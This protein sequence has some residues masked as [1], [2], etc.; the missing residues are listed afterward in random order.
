MSRTAIPVA[1]A[2]LNGSVVAS[3]AAIDIANGM[4]LSGFP[5]RTVVQI[6]NTAGSGHTVTVEAGDPVGGVSE[7]LAETFFVPAGAAIWLGPQSSSR[8]QQRDGSLYFDFEAGHTG[9]V[10]AL[11]M[12]KGY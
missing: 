3:T 6:T 2:V 4:S 12:Q 8:V 10:M 1:T 7:Q 11:A 9:T 5:E